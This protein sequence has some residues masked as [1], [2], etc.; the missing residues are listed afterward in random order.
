MSAT[1]I[2]SIHIYPVKSLGG[3]SVPHVQL[4]DRGLAHD[5]RWMLVDEAGRFLS[6]REVPAMACLHCGPNGTGFTVTDVRHGSSV[7]LPWT[8]DVGTRIGARVWEDEVDLL[9]GTGPMHQW[10]SEA[11]HRPLRLAYMPESTVRPTDPKYAEARVALSDAFPA[12]VISRASLDDLNARLETPV[13]MERFRPNFVLSGGR[14]YQ[15]DDWKEFTLGTVNFKNVKPCARCVIPNTDQQT[16]VRSAEPLRT[17]ASYR[18][19]GNKVLFGMNAI[20]DA[21][22]SVREGDV[23][24]IGRSDDQM[25]SVPPELAW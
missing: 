10:F 21:G 14:P 6:Q 19:M 17:L 25:I 7:D 24:M 18:S 16:G 15:E 1:T 3:F 12:L 9:L 5:R 2:A 4:T 11:L 22:G 13:P 8:L 20:F 23:V